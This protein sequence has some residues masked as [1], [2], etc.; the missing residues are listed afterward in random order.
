VRVEDTGGAGGF[1]GAADQMML[2]RADGSGDVIS[3][4]GEWQWQIVSDAPS[5][6][7]QHRP[8][9]LYN[10]MIHGLRNY[11]I[12]GAI[13][14]QGESNAIGERG[15]EYFTL[16]PGMIA[17]WRNQ[18]G[19]PTL[20]FIFVQLPD[21]T[22]N[23]PH[24]PWRYPLLRQAQLETHRAV[25]NTGMAVTLDL[26]AAND[27][28][29]RNKH[30]VGDRLARWALA[31]V[32]GKRIAVKCAPLPQRADFNAD[33]GVVV[34]FTTFGSALTSRDGEALRGFEVAG[35]D[36]KWMPATARIDGNRV[37]VFSGD[38]PRPQHVRY[39]WL[40]NTGDCNLANEQGMPASPFLFV[41]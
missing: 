6:R 33:Q 36:G 28:H 10:A 38:A 11:A 25:A 22:N 16:F 40:N 13:W 39:A 5:V 18:F 26:G 17:D 35:A 3:L 30:D 8:A 9:N 1:N 7:I 34:H 24:T 31:D 20:P 21:F 4:A 32:Y 14:Y 19:N 37:V 29:P 15:E 2:A 27:I 12:R 23:E 41:R